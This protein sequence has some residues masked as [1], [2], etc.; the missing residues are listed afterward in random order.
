MKR[1]KAR[2]AG[3]VWKAPLL[4]QSKAEMPGVSRIR[5][6]RAAKYEVVRSCG[7]A[8]A[9]SRTGDDHSRT[10]FVSADFQTCRITDPPESA[11]R[12]AAL[13]VGLETSAANAGTARSNS[14][15]ELVARRFLPSVNLIRETRNY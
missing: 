9:A 13:E 8:N 2:V 15:F 7:T 3:G 14:Q 4:G 1:E 11:E 10:V 6:D 12:E 5:N